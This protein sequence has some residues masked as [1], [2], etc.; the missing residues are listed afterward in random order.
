MNHGNLL[1]IWIAATE[2]GKTHAVN[3]VRATAGAGLEGDRYCSS[4]ADPGT[5][6]TLIEG[7]EIDA[8]N[9]AL[10]LDLAPGLFRRNLVTQSVRLN[11]LVGRAFS[12]G[13]VQL[14]GIELCEPCAYLQNLLEVPELVKTLTHRGGVR[15]EI[16]SSGPLRGGE[17]IQPV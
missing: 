16:L 5:Q 8:F 10:D 7:E 6:L 14:R 17:T 11:D 2:G 12:V 4:T 3:E 1:A 9:A 15:C 13:D